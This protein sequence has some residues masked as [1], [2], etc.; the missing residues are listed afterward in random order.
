MNKYVSDF[1]PAVLVK[2]L[3]QAFRSRGYVALLLLCAAGAWLSAWST[4]VD[5]HSV[6]DGVGVFVRV[7]W[8]GLLMVFVFLFCIPWRAGSAVKGD[9]RV[10]GTNFLMLTP[11]TSRRI[12]W[13]VWLSSVVQMLLMLVPFVPLYLYLE[14]HGESELNTLWQIAAAGVVMSAVQ[15]FAARL[16]PLLRFGLLAYILMQVLSVLFSSSSLL[17]LLLQP[18]KG[19]VA[20]SAWQYGGMGALAAL[21]V[22]LLLEFTRRYY[23]PLTENCSVGYRTVLPVVF[24][25]GAVLC[26]KGETTIG[27]EL[28][29]DFGG[30]DAPTSVF[31]QTLVNLRTVA[32]V[33]I[34]LAALADAVMPSCR[35]PAHDRRCLP[36][37]PKLLQVPGLA[38]ATLWL[39]IALGFGF[40]LEVMPAAGADPL[41]AL[42]EAA[43]DAARGVLDTAYMVL[44]CLLAVD[45]CCKR[46]S[47]LRPVVF[48]VLLAALSLF[49]AGMFF[50]AEGET[51]GGTYPAWQGLL[52]HILMADTWE[53]LPPEYHYL[54]AAACLAVVALL[55]YRGRLKQ[56]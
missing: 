35:I 43:P 31:L 20:V 56:V 8:H 10:K 37:L 50:F 3:R 12:V 7:S 45:V 27:Y 30:A 34:L 42:R 6:S 28:Q 52:P 46:E 15:M 51:A 40:L 26:W 39:V 9:T 21:S 25:V 11:V 13:S 18:G 49:N 4:V 19:G 36:W 29:R 41:A 54:R 53:H 24:A 55:L 2:D 23:A 33:M 44:L 47:A 32:A 14:H 16:H 5:E 22:V 48:F 1:L 17:L 38:A